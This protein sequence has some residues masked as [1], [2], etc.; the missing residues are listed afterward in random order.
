MCKDI[1]NFRG[2]FSIDNLPTKPWAKESCIVNLSVSRQEGSH[3]VC[4]EKKG[5]TVRYFNSFGNLRPPFEIVDYLKDC[6][7]LY[8]RKSYQKY[9]QKICGQLCVLFL[10]GIIR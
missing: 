2:I 9:S 5:K 10:K 6:R 4:F 3:W 7:F 1:K 8:N